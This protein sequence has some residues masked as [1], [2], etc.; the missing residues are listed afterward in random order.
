MNPF[1]RILMLAISVAC[2]SSFYGIA[3]DSSHAQEDQPTRGIKRSLA[4]YLSEDSSDD[5]DTSSEVRKK[6]PPV[7]S[8]K[9]VPFRSKERDAQFRTI[10]RR[11]PFVEGEE[12][13]RLVWTKKLDIFS[14]SKN[15]QRFAE[16]PA[17]IHNELA[18]VG[19]TVRAF[20]QQNSFAPLSFKRN[21]LIPHVSFV[22]NRD[23]GRT[24]QRLFIRGDYLNFDEER[25]SDCAMAFISG[26][27]SMPWMA[28]K[29]YNAYRKTYNS[30]PEREYDLPF[31]R[32]FSGRE[33]EK[34]L[35]KKLPSAEQQNP[36]CLYHTE[37]MFYEMLLANPGAVV[38]QAE[39]VLKAGDE[40]VHIVFDF[41][42]WWDVCRP[43][44]MRFRTEYFN[45]IVHQKLEQKF[46]E[47]GFSFSKDA[48]ILPIFRVSSYRQHH[49]DS[50]RDMNTAGSANAGR[51]GFEAKV[52]S[53]AQV[54]LATRQTTGSFDYSA[55]LQ[56][57][58]A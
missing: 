11:S 26:G 1:Y 56:K 22:V 35:D 17:D 48:G 44:Q 13:A 24:I 21:I 32:V 9:F 49:P 25:H 27:D 50:L 8:P 51:C 14:G 30:D 7:L 47:T 37:E 42:S 58:Q 34:L 12:S 3:A 40:V 6:P 57:I 4:R 39:K 45:G 29:P 16:I 52:L 18:F 23:N 54:V 41:Y 38:T 10:T 19:N 53:Q 20:A 43:C 2:F 28:F 15:P 33:V 55:I 31:V 36:E 5:S 46:D